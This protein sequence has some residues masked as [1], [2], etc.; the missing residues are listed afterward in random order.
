MDAL[1]RRIIH[2]VVRHAVYH[3]PA[4]PRI[5]VEDKA[6]GKC[7]ILLAVE[8]TAAGMCG[9]FGL[10]IRIDAVLLLEGCLAGHTVQRICAEVDVISDGAGIGD[11]QAVVAVPC[12]VVPDRQLDAAEDAYR[13][14]GIRVDGLT[15]LYEVALYCKEIVFVQLR[16][17][18]TE[19][20]VRDG[21]IRHVDIEVRVKLYL[22]DDLGLGADALGKLEQQIPCGNSGNIAACDHRQQRLD[23][24]RD[25]Y[26]SHVEAEH[27]GD[28]HRQARVKDMVTVGLILAGGELLGVGDVSRPGEGSVAGRGIVKVEYRL[29]LAVHRDL[30]RRAYRVVA[31]DLRGDGRI[32]E[33][34]VGAAGECKAKFRRFNGTGRIVAEVKLY[35]VRT[36]GNGILIIGRYQRQVHGLAVDSVDRGLCKLQS[37][38]LH[39]SQRLAADDLAAGHELYLN[40]AALDRGKHAIGCYRADTLIGGDPAYVRRQL[41]CTAGS[42]DAGGGEAHRR[43]LG[44]II[45]ICGN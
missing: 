4:G 20:I 16:A 37:V 33:A 12:R 42:A 11:G 7:L 45:V 39:D 26:S 3:F 34:G 21:Q 14:G 44:E 23:L 43:T 31:G 19:V 28:V 32:S 15:L 22:D 36:D 13:I 24:F 8:V 6:V 30:Y 5:I 2:K 41:R 18:E 10:L 9:V 27:I 17:C 40:A 1:Q 29:I 35:I 25:A 38:R